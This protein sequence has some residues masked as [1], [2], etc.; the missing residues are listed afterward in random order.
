MKKLIF[1]I[2]ALAIVIITVIV[3]NL[4]PYINKL[5]S[6]NWY[7]DSCKYY[8]DKYKYDKE[9]SLTTLVLTQ[10]QKDKYLDLLKEGKRV[11]DNK[12]A[13]VGLE[14]A[15][16]NINIFFGFIC[17]VLGLLLYLNMASN[18]GK[19]IGLIGLGSGIIG[20]VLTLVYIIESGIIFTQY[21]IDKKYDDLAT[22]FS[23]ANI[24]IDKDGAFLKYDE[25]KKS[26]VCIFYEKDNENSLYLKYSDYGNKYLNYN[27]DIKFADEEKNYKYEFGCNYGNNNPNDDFYLIVTPKGTDEPTNFYETCK[28][29]DEEK[30]YYAF[31]TNKEKIPYYD[32]ITK[33]K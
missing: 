33:F 9:K 26:Y 25:S 29:L 24:K 7:D 16:L 21:V 1:L 5:K 17:A 11:C 2:I 13:M 3:L 32:S 19:I 28:M 8:I 23:S 10:E 14:Y 30:V 20:F 31:G 12:K 15:S 22:K 18:I 4:C 6:G 27:K